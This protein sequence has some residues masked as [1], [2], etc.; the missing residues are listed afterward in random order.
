MQQYYN[1]E[2]KIP[3]IQ[4]TKKELSKLEKIKKIIKITINKIVDKQLN[5]KNIIENKNG[6]YIVEESFDIDK[7]NEYFKN[8]YYIPYDDKKH[9]KL[10]KKEYILTLFRHIEQYIPTSNINN[11]LIEE[12]ISEKNSIISTKNCHF[13]IEFE[14]IKNLD[15]NKDEQNMYIL[16]PLKYSHVL[17]NEYIKYLLNYYKN[18]DE[19]S[20]FIKLLVKNHDVSNYMENYNFSR[21][22]LDINTVDLDLKFVILSFFIFLVKYCDKKYLFYS[23]DLSFKDKT[24]ESQ[25][26]G[27]HRNG[28]FIKKNYSNNKLTSIDI[29][30][31]E[32]HGTKPRT[33]ISF[34]YDK[35]EVDEYYKKIDSII[36]SLKQNTMYNNFLVDINFN[37]KEAVCEI[38][39]QSVS[40]EEDIG[41]CTIFSSFWV[42]SFI[43]ILNTINKYDNKFLENLSDVPIKDWIKEIDIAISSIKDNYNIKYSKEIKYKFKDIYMLKN[44]NI[45]EDIIY[46]KSKLPNYEDLTYDIDDKFEELLNRMKD[47][48]HI[49]ITIDEFYDEYYKILD[50]FYNFYIEL[51]KDFKEKD[52]YINILNKLIK[53]IKSKKYKLNTLEHFSIFINYAYNLF[54]K[55]H[56]PIDEY[57]KKFPEE[58]KEN[59]KIL[60]E[61]INDDNFIK[62]IDRIMKKNLV[63]IEDNNSSAIF[64][65][66]YNKNIEKDKEDK[67]NKNNK[68]IGDLLSYVY[69]S[70]KIYSEDEEQ[71]RTKD[72]EWLKKEQ[73]EESNKIYEKCGKKEHI[74]KQINPKLKCEFDEITNEK[75]CKPPDNVKTIGEQ[76]D[77]NKDCLTDYCKKYKKIVNGKEKNVGIC[78]KK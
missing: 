54:E 61:F 50:N 42:Y 13:I 74:C 49:L 9:F 32:P 25:I 58:N 23:L 62:L 14:Y 39:I 12:L 18:E 47:N 76:C 64:N 7:I 15:S 16:V 68:N 66:K 37:S 43:N 2:K 6:E 8:E 59:I 51:I 63:N 45:E 55:M 28:L 31:Y 78:R 38:G 5:K 22:K 77:V 17:V 52:I 72:L 44:Q 4:I 53:N 48:M 60:N 21:F 73:E 34:S 69:D 3:D 10:N 26:N 41:Y 33:G 40:R 20:H 75:I 24:Q 67:N 65:L 70:K 36:D 35:F 46:I 1:F 19:I 29:F 57:K 11:I 27:E 56:N 71:K 30:H